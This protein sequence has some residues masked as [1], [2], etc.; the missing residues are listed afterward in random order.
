MPVK[1]RLGGMVVLSGLLLVLAAN[2]GADGGFV[3]PYTLVQGSASSSAQAAVLIHEGPDEVLLLRTTY[4]GPAERFAWIVPVPARPR[5]VFAANPQFVS[6]ALGAASPL[7]V[8]HI[9]PTNSQRQ[10]LGGSEGPKRSTSGRVE[11]LGQMVVANMLASVLQSDDGA[12]LLTWLHDSNY[13]VADTAVPLL[14]TYARAGWVFVALK[15][16][17]QT[18]AARSLL[19]DVPPLGLRFDA[20]GQN[21]LF[22]LR[23]SRLS[24]PAQSAILLSVIGTTPY[25]CRTLPTRRLSEAVALTAGETYG[26]LRRRLARERGPALVCE[27]GVR[28]A[29]RF[30]TFSYRKDDQRPFMSGSEAMLVTTGFFALLRP[31]EMEDLVFEPDGD[32]DLES[33]RVT[34]ERTLAR[35]PWQAT[36]F[37]PEGAAPPGIVGP[38]QHGRLATAGARRLSVLD[39]VADAV[40]RFREDT[41]ALPPN[42]AALETMPASGWDASGNPVPISGWKGPY[43]MLPADAMKR[44]PPL[45]F[46][47]L[48]PRFMDVAVPATVA[49]RNYAGL[50]VPGRP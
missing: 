7:T 31:E 5:E 20:T 28:G 1:R 17:E 14:T 41:G 32:P 50:R 10:G 3:G 38:D 9:N 18:A 19:E 16:L 30:A 42:R 37:F 40:K 35:D 43:L 22:P 47:A 11:V 15:M 2:A 26:G 45:V 46:D 4:R 33:Y 36:A 39:V 34:I 48:N 44:L 49:P 21:L 6:L 29:Q 24:A 27:A 13:A 12:A 25:R 8:T 23:I